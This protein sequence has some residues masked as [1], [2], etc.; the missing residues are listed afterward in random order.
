MKK[1]F[2]GLLP[3]I[4]LFSFVVQPI[5]SASTNPVDSK[6]G[7]SG[8]DEFFH[9][10]T[11]TFLQSIVDV[12]DKVIEQGIEPTISWIEN[13]TGLELFD[14]NGIMRMKVNGDAEVDNEFERMPTGVFGCSAAILSAIAGVGIPFTKIFKLKKAINALGGVGKFVD[15]VIDLATYYKGKGYGK[16][17]ALKKAIREL[18]DNL[19]SDLSNA[20]LDLA[21]ITAITANCTSLK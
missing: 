2:V 21:G 10:D 6:S 11:E 14:D 19:S 13:D 1:F 4:L 8:H 12:P 17:Q 7:H 16:G 9:E 15:D 20:L 5:A 3:A 18:D